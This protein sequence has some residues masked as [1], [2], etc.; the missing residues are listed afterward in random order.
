MTEAEQLN[1]VSESAPATADMPDYLLEPNAV[2]LDQCRWRHG[3][4]RLSRFK[5]LA[6]L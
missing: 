6:A 3:Q 5:V 1:V 4:V 2:L